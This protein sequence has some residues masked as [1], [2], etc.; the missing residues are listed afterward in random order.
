MV[1]HKHNVLTCN[2]HCLCSGS[3]C[4]W[5]TT[6]TNTLWLD[7][8]AA[9]KL[10]FRRNYQCWCPASE[11]CLRAVT[12]QKQIGADP[13]LT[14]PAP[15]S[16]TPPS[17][18]NT[19]LEMWRTRR[20]RGRSQRTKARKERKWRGEERER[21]RKEMARLRGSERTRGQERERAHE[22][23]RERER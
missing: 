5:F 6:E 2:K 18:C 7:T 17:T 20:K 8:M 9:N 4:C 22:R 12:Q 23:E 15:W 1:W 11:V 13:T 3:C 21:G 16:N 19:S 14:S 10:V